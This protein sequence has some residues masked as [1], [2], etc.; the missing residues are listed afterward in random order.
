MVQGHR[1]RPPLAA[2]RELF[3]RLIAR[4]IGNAEGQIRGP[5]GYP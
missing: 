5:W 4:G 1:G 2:K 3:G